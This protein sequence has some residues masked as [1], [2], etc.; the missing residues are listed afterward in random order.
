MRIDMRLV[1]MHSIVAVVANGMLPETPLPDAALAPVGPHGRQGLCFWYGL[2]KCNLDRS[3]T[4]R[5]AG[6]AL[7]QGP[8]V[9]HVIGKHH[10]SVYVERTTR[11]HFPYRIAQS[12][13]LLD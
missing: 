8:N 10:P 12:I 11:P 1:N 5:V 2:R 9:M 4:A 7:W 13:D 3:P 6:V